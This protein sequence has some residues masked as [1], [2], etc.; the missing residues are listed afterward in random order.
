MLPAKIQLPLE[1]K[2]KGG[3]KKKKKSRVGVLDPNHY[4]PPITRSR[5]PPNEG[6]PT[7]HWGESSPDQK[8][9][10]IPLHSVCWDHTERPRNRGMLQDCQEIHLQ[11]PSHPPPVC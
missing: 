9:P 3:E 2:K 6:S 7:A 11:D 5:P 1:K 10:K 8:L 4:S